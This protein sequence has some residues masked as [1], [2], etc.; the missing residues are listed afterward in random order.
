MYWIRLAAGQLLAQSRLCRV[1]ALYDNAGHLSGYSKRR[2]WYAGVL[3]RL[4]NVLTFDVY[5]LPELEWIEWEIRIWNKIHSIKAQVQQ[6]TLITPPIRGQLLSS[7]LQSAEIEDAVKVNALGTALCALRRAHQV[8]VG[9]PDGRVAPFSHG[10]A[11]VRNVFVDISNDT[12]VWFDFE[13]IH[14]TAM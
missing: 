2:A 5:C 11:H 14:S 7:I 4:A 13:I 3:I 9:W 6:N 12:A 10:D 8:D 1:K